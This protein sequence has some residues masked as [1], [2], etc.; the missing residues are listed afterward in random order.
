MERTVL[1]P[2][3]L[4]AD[5]DGVA[6][7]IRFR[8]HAVGCRRQTVVAGCAVLLAFAGG[9]CGGGN[10]GEGTGEPGEV[11]VDLNGQN[12]A[13]VSGARAVFGYVADDRTLVTIDG[14]DG[15]ERGAAGPNAARIV[16]GS[17]EEPAEVVYELRPLEGTTSETEIDT[18][19]DRLYEGD[20]AVQVLFAKTGS[21]VLACG[22]LPDEPPA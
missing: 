6:W 1:A 13:N 20:Y 11:S 18:G 10:G 3:C 8:N 19:I 22:D 15:A 2:V 16:V 4:P 14:L 17:C 5:E 7:V 9:G 12:D 21:K